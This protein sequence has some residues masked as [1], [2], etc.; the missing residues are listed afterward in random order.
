MDHDLTMMIYGALM[1]V[2]GSIVSSL[3]TTIFQFWLARREYE[4]KQYEEQH[5]QMNQ[6][7]LPTEEEVIAILQT[8]NDQEPQVSHKAAQ[9][10]SL[11]LSVVVSSFL[12]YQTK[13]PWLGF[14]FST[15]LSFVIT[16]RVMR[17]FRRR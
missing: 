15:A 5:K 10:G 2:V 1:G 9:A 8:Q 16:N 7:Y 3:V 17:F 4:R 11:V 14:A 13:N 6:I 12:I